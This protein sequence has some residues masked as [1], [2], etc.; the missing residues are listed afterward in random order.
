MLL[1]VEAFAGYQQ[2]EAFC[3]WAVRK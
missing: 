2:P 1:N 3:M